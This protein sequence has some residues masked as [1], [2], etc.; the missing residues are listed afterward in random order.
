VDLVFADPPY[1][2]RRFGA[3]L[4]AVAP[5]LLSGGELVLE[6][7]ARSEPAAIAGL[8]VEERRRYGDTVLTFLRSA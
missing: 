3:L 2:F 1:T 5:R 4:A 7:S 6:H 8:A